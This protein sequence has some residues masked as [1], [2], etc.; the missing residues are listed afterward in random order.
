MESIFAPFRF[1]PFKVMDARH[2]AQKHPKVEIKHNKKQP[3]NIAPLY[4]RSLSSSQS[5]SHPSVKPLP[6]CRPSHVRSFFV[7]S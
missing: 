3:E 2:V 5:P 6:R 4:S 1:A 7:Y